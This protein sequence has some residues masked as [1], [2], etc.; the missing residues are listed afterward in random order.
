MNKK[1]FKGQPY[2]LGLDIGNASVGAAILGEQRILG[3][4]VR[5]FNKAETAKEGES[6]NKIRRESRLSRRR[7]RRRAHRMLRLL[8]LMK[9][10][11]LIEETNTDVFKQGKINPISPWSLKI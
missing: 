2:R 7:I 5:T 11:G 10:V 9:R 4:H 3:L 6:L 1:Q 8:R